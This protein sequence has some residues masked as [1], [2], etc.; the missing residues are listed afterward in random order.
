MA[1]ASFYQSSFLGGEW[2]LAQ[3]GR[4]DDPRYRT[5]MSVCLNGLQLETGAWVRRPGFMFA[6]RTPR[7]APARV[8][9]LNF[10]SVQP[11]SMEFSDGLIRFRNGVAF[12]MIN[13]PL[14]VISI[15]TDN[16]ARVRFSQ[17]HGTNTGEYVQFSNLGLSLPTLQN[18]QFQVTSIDA[19]TLSIA[20]DLLGGVDGSLL[21]ALPAGVI[22]S[23]LLQIIT[24]YTKGAAND[25]T[26]IRVVQAETQALLLNGQAPN[27]VT[28]LTQPTATQ[29]ATFD[30]RSVTFVDGPYLDP[31]NGNTSVIT[32]ASIVLAYTGTGPYT[33]AAQQQGG[34]AAP[35]I[36][37]ATDVGRQM[38]LLSAPPT[39]QSATSYASNALVT[40]NFQ[41]FKNVSGGA[42]AGDQP[43]LFPAVWTLQTGQRTIW[44]YGTITAY[45]SPTSVQFSVLGP[46]STNLALYTTPIEFW[47]LGVYSTTTG[48]PTCGC[49]HEN[50]VWL[51]GAVTNRFDASMS[52]GLQPGS[53]Q[54]LMSPTGSD[55]TVATNNGLSYTLAAKDVNQILWME[56]EQQGIVCGTKGGEW[57]VQA[58]AQNL[59]LSP[60]NIQAHRYTTVGCANVEPKHS[61]MTLLFVQK[62]GRKVMEFF[63]DVYAGRFTAPN[64]V[65]DA[66]H[67]TIGGILEL[68]YQQ[69]LSPLLWARRGDGALI[70][71]T[72]KRESLT[73]HD[74]PTFSA[75]HRHTLG[76]GRAVE[77]I[78]T[79]GNA[80]GTLDALTV[81]TN[82]P[83]TNIRWVEV[84]SDIPDENAGL[85]PAWNLDA[86]V[87][88]SSYQINIVTDVP[89]ALGLNGLWHL[90]GKTVTVW[91]GGLDIGDWPVVNG[92]IAVPF[93]DGVNSGPAGTSNTT[94]PFR[95]GGGGYLLTPDF[96]NSFAGAMPIV[97]GFNYECDGQILRPNTQAESGA[98]N[99]PA[100]GKKRLQ[101]MMA[102]QTVNTQ[103]IEFGT[104]FTAGR[105]QPAYFKD[106]AGNTLPVNQLFSGIFWSTIEDVWSY[107]GMLAWRVTRPYPATI[108]AIGGFLKTNDY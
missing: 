108:A 9:S 67:L 66:K 72:Y 4:M 91:A 51:A 48:W 37:A 78:A 3:Q 57:L 33:L 106:L 31:F 81:V 8:M 52:F 97:V 82:D 96:V 49:Y 45:N 60:T 54:I 94:G 107:D 90:N 58:T 25:W 7:G 59:P 38:R 23:R 101:N 43:D 55:G 65:K 24:T 61:P 20:D 42:I 93:G 88:P 103:G 85:L 87:A 16:P 30:Y 89:V 70:G 26:N 32:G 18:R 15:S 104:A 98:R 1:D 47:R 68:A 79:C 63:P 12:A 62:Q 50:R 21:G 76:S 14:A 83:A 100:F 99:G 29:F 80:T 77:S 71:C 102:L 84:L 11:Y 74:L 36:F 10:T 19:Y 40:Y 13:A 27:I 56:P 5:A 86:S 41:V 28:V 105:M 44:V 64:L 53:N 95:P 22:A 17:P 39:W 35:A 75:W 34:G 46:G 69:E 2:S 73:A 92:S 6:G